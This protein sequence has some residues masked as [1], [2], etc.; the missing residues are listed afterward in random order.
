MAAMLN[1][2][3]MGFKSLALQ[4][5]SGRVW[6]T[7]EKVRSEFAKFSKSLGDVQKKLDAAQSELE[8]LVGTRTRTLQKALDKASRSDEE[9]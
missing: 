6:D 1:S 8:N 5:S 7:L 3:R 9:H 2:F 4:Q